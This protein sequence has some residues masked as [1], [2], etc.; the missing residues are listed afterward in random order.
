[1]FS[2]SIHCDDDDK[3]VDYDIGDGVDKENDA[4][5]IKF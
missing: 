2:Q 1:M 5:A 4:D 3:N